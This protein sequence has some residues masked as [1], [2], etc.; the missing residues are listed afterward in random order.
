LDIPPH[1]HVRQR[2]AERIEQTAHVACAE[3]QLPTQGRQLLEPQ[4][5]IRTLNPL[6][7]MPKSSP[8]LGAVIP[9]NDDVLKL[10]I[11]HGLRHRAPFLQNR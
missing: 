5:L 11:A 9:L 8:T 10:R 3:A 4:T 1:A 6:G 7:I 2:H